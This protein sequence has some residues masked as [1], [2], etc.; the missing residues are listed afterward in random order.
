MK[1]VKFRI[2]FTCGCH[3]DRKFATREAGLAEVARCKDMKCNECAAQSANP[4]VTVTGRLVKETEKAVLFSLQPQ[5]YETQE[6]QGEIWFPKSQ[7][8]VL[9]RAMGSLDQIEM[10]EWIFNQKINS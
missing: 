9:E 6:L 4:T 1:K 10:S 3:K 5:S 2:R 8:T 7:V